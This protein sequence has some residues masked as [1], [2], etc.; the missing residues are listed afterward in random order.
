MLFRSIINEYISLDK[1][2]VKI[3]DNKEE[4]ITDELKEQ[5]EISK[6]EKNIAE[7]STV[8]YIKEQTENSYDNENLNK[9]IDYSADGTGERE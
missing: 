4:K 6:S 9:I 2:S 1:K 3:T 5:H 7:Q 8:T